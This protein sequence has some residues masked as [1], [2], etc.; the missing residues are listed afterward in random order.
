MKQE[1]DTV[2]IEI[3][4]QDV[5]MMDV[6]MPFTLTP[7]TTTALPPLAPA[8]IAPLVPPTD[9]HSSS[10][11]PQKPKRTKLA[12]KP[13]DYAPR[14]AIIPIMSIPPPPIED[15]PVITIYEKNEE[16]EMTPEAREWSKYK[17]NS[18]PPPK[19]ALDRAIKSGS[20]EGM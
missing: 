10:H 12:Y 2:K 15:A 19:L 4:P 16:D 11:S 7:T 13:P 5:S 3:K 14:T 1:H 20:M 17:K 18:Y 8:V 6:T 9:A